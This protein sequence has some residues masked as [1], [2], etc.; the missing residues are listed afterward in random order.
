MQ[1][2]VIRLHALATWERLNPPPLPLRHETLADYDR[3]WATWAGQRNAAMLRDPAFRAECR[4]RE[5]AEEKRHARIRG[6]GRF[7]GRLHQ[8]IAD[9]ERG[10]PRD[11]RRFEP[12]HEYLHSGA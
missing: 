2:N 4:A 10:G 5:E 11:R 9:A 3:R 8:K 1:D 7:A 12:D 6:V